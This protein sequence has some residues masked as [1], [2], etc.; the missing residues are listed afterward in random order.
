MSGFL[1]DTN[2]ISEVVQPR[3]AQTV[4]DWVTGTDE[5]LLYL[6]VLTVGELRKGISLL[7][8]GRRRAS[9]EAWLDQELTFRFSGRILP[10]DLGIAERWGRMCGSDV[11]RRS[12]LP[13]IDGLLAATALHYDLVFVSRDTAHAISHGVTAVDPWKE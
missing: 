1:L 5:N 8:I 9:L 12:P 10:I 7:A 3:P 11:A 4:L 13:I 6:S 2:V